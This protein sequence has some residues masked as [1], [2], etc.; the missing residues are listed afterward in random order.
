MTAAQTLEIV[1]GPF[2]SMRVIGGVRVDFFP[3]S[4]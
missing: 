4:C 3:G 1:Y 2:H